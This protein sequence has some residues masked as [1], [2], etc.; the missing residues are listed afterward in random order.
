M[1]YIVV[2]I[3]GALALSACS[4]TVTQEQIAAK[5]FEYNQKEVK[6]T[7]KEIPKWFLDVPT[8]EG[9]MYAVGSAQT[10]DLQLTIDIAILGAKNTLADSMNSRLRSQTKQFVTKLGN[11]DLDSIV[12]T[13]VEKATRNLVLDA[14]VS[15]WQQ[16][17][18]EIYPSGSQYRAYVLLEYSDAMATN[19]LHKRILQ[20]SSL[21]SKIRSTEA[22]KEL[23][24]A[25]NEYN[26]T[27]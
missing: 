5:R 9:K 24:A 4:K 16:K 22:F 20:N 2:P 27:E 18:L 15:G 25:V 10:P 23:D 3:I 8:E 1:K 19:I 7:V 12:M 13:E 14:D 6:E 17:E 21:H 11:D 26:E